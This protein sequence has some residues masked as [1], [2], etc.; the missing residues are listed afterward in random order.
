MAKPRQRALLVAA[1]EEDAANVAALQG[2]PA[3][4]QARLRLCTCKYL[5]H[6]NIQIALYRAV[7]GAFK[8]FWR[9]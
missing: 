3:N 9:R 2:A 7:A 5:G 6:R 1:S 8:D 4:A